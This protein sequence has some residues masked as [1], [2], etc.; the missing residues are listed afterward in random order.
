MIPD[1]DDED[2]PWEDSP[3]LPAPS[4]GKGGK[5]TEVC[6]SF[7]YKMNAGNYESRDF[8]MSMKMEC[9][10]EDAEKVSDFLHKK[11]VERVMRSVESYS[12]K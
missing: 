5:I 10:E 11:C 7:S 4:A 6:R 12:K 9:F 1:F 2:P 3:K 8:F